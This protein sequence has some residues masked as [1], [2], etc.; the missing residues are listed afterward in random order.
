MLDIIKEYLISIGATLDK[1]SFKQAEQAMNGVEKKGAQLASNLGKSFIKMS[2][3][4]AGIAATLAVGM[5]KFALSVGEADRQMG[6]LA[7]RLYTTKENARALSAAM[8]AMNFKSI[9]DLRNLGLDPEAREQFIELK[10]L[11]RSLEN[12]RT[13][14]AM[15]EIREINFEIQKMMVRFEYFK[16]EVA[17]KILEIFRKM[18]PYIQKT[19]D[20]FKPIAKTMQDTIGAFKGA[21]PNITKGIKYVWEIVKPIINTI[22]ATAI[23]IGKIFKNI[24]DG[25]KNMPMGFK[26]AFETIKQVLDPVIKMFQF[27]E[28]IVVYLAGGK[29]RF[30]KIYDTF[31]FL[32]HG[33]ENISGKTSS[34]GEQLDRQEQRKKSLDRGYGYIRYYRRGQT[35]QG[36]GINSVRPQSGISEAN[37]KMLANINRIMGGETRGIRISAGTEGKHSAGSKHYAG[38]ALDIETIQSTPMAQIIRLM[39]AAQQSQQVNQILLEYSQAD[40]ERLRQE[41]IRQ[42]QDPEAFRQYLPTTLFGKP[43][44]A[45]AGNSHIHLEPKPLTN[46][47]QFERQKQMFQGGDTNYNIYISGGTEALEKKKEEVRST[48]QY[49]RGGY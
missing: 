22:R 36:F 28:D 21:I 49:L 30:E 38:G 39:R 5:G 23:I 16:L 24:F 1:D 32:R 29:S 12:P 11:A 15:R 42:G 20:W 45:T 27:I 8:K 37:A 7:N 26:V 19:I 9:E 35:V 34:E 14:Q 44:Y 18:Q 4:F 6:F 41:L 48:I 40:Y 46:Q 47:E 2:A 13:A 43:I 17:A 25:I 33:R 31:D 3:A 10:N